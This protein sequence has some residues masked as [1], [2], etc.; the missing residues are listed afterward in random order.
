ML[1]REFDKLD[2]GLD[3][4]PWLPC[5]QEGYNN[6]CKE[7]GGIWATSII[8]TEASWEL[9]AEAEIP[10]GLILAPSAR[11]FCAY[12]DDGNSMST[13]KLCGKGNIHGNATC[14]PGCYGVGKQCADIVSAHKGD[15]A[16]NGKY[17]HHCSYPPSQLYDALSAHKAFLE[18]LRLHPSHKWNEMVVDLRSIVEALPRSIEGFFCQPKANG[19]QRRKV[20]GL[21]RSF[22]EMYYEAP[23]IEWARAHNVSI[24]EAAASL[25]RQ[26]DVA[27]VELDLNL[28]LSGEDPF[29]P[30][31]V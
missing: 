28:G 26:P 27:L 7:W 9:Y 24:E 15:A 4:K 2:D 17:P 21:Q 3:G 16:Y 10:C 20:M 23:R 1:V 14:T 31:A 22:V 19:A 25:G 18:D 11:L 8:S 12:H 29:R 13:D 5:P 6:W 30:M